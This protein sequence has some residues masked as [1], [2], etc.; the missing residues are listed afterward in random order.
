MEKGKFITL[1]QDQCNYIKQ[2]PS[3]TT[4]K[5]FLQEL[6]QFIGDV[7]FPDE[8][9]S[10]IAMHLAGSRFIHPVRLFGDGTHTDLVKTWSPG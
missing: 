10:Y 1:E 9:V 5:L 2:L 7:H 8:E 6:Q 4:T 3:Y